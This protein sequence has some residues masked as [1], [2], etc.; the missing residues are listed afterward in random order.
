MRSG[1]GWA[2]RVRIVARARARVLVEAEVQRSARRRL[3]RHG[4]RLGRPDWSMTR[5]SPTKE[6]MA[7][8]IRDWTSRTRPLVWMPLTAEAEGGL[9]APM[10]QQRT[11]AG[12]P[13]HQAAEAGTR[14]LWKTVC[15]NLAAAAASCRLGEV[16]PSSRPRRVAAPHRQRAGDWQ[17]TVG[18][19]ERLAEEER[20]VRAR[21]EQRLVVVVLV[22][23]DS[24]PSARACLPTTRGRINMMHRGLL[25]AWSVLTPAPHVA[26]QQRAGGEHTSRVDSRAPS[27]PQLRHASYEQASKLRSGG[28]AR[29]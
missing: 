4:E 25:S 21:L 9:A 17:W 8:A 23:T 24:A 1:I 26:W 5:S 18:S 27:L 12:V 10:E 14:A 19:S 28:H 11:V 20:G 2:V 15:G 3:L 22:P 16:D 29:C 6:R 7:E 13:G